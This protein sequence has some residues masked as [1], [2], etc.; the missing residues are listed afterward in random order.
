LSLQAWRQTDDFVYPQSAIGGRPTPL[1]GGKGGIVCDAIKL[2]KREPESLTRRYT[3]EIIDAVQSF[4]RT[5]EIG[6][7]VALG[8]PR[9]SVLRLLASRGALLPVTGLAAGALGGVAPAR[10][11]G[12]R[13]HR[14]ALAAMKIDPVR[15]LRAESS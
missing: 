4:Q 10:D 15:A 9:A 13:Q 11:R 8:A 1:S 7:R 14:A 3:G 12:H 2:S 6:I 5:H